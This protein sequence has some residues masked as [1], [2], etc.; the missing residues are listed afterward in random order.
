MDSYDTIYQWR[1]VYPRANQK[2][3]CPTLTYNMGSGGHNVPLIKTKHT[4]EDG[5]DIRKLTPYEVQLFQG[6][7]KDFVFPD[8]LSDSKK[9]NQIGNSVTV[10][11]ISKI[12]EKIKECL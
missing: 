7:P 3:V 10:P 5:E 12:A 4:S 8:D 9:Y 6:F 1:R 11:L 2:N